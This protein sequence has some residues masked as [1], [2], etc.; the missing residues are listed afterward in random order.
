MSD[1]DKL[2][3]NQA[4]KVRADTLTPQEE[5]AWDLLDMEQ[6]VRLR[7]SRTEFDNTFH[8][9]SLCRELYLLGSFEQI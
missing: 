2:K 7:E 1:L 3:T 9:F 4:E 6:A 8:W 5:E